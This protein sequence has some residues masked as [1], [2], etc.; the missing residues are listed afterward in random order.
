[1][2]EFVRQVV[3]SLRR[4][5]A[6]EYLRTRLRPLALAL[7]RTHVVAPPAAQEAVELVKPPL[8][9]VLGIGR[10]EVPFPDEGGAIAGMAQVAGHGRDLRVHPATTFLD[11]VRHAVARLVPTGHQGGAGRTAHRPGHIAVGEAHTGGGQRVEMRRRDVLASMHPAI[12]I[13]HVVGHDEHDIG[14]GR[15]RSAHGRHRIEGQQGDE[16]DYSFSSFLHV[17]TRIATGSRLL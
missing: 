6:T 7:V 1:M 17:F 3:A 12:R 11:P 8:H 13:P 4:F 10:A 9:R 14:A 16:R 5:A 15:L 2:A